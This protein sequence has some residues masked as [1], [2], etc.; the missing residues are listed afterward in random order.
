MTETYN[1]TVFAIDETEFWTELGPKGRREA[2]AKI[3][4]ARRNER[5]LHK[6]LRTAP[7]QDAKDAAISAILA[8][9]DC[10]LASVVRVQKELPARHRGTLE[11]CLA[12]PGCQSAGNFDPVSARNNDPVF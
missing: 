6:A 1:M 5:L 9:Q 8:S 4:A 2:L 10:A 11:E 3:N 12:A 7:A